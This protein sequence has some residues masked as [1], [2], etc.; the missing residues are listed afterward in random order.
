MERVAFDPSGQILAV[1]GRRGYI[2]LVDWRA[3][4]AQVIGNVKMNSGVQALWWNRHPGHNSISGHPE[5]LTLGA[6]AEV[7]VWDIGERRCVRR[8]KE[9]GGYGTTVMSGDTS[10]RYLSIGSKS[11]LVNVYGEDASIPIANSPSPSSS[12][13]KPQKTLQNLTTSISTLRFNHDSQLLAMASSVK[14]D[15]MRLVH[16]PSLTAFSNWP[17]SSTPLGHVTAIDFSPTSQYIA[18]GNNRGRALL[19]Q[20]P[21]FVKY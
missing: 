21:Q 13:P 4:G 19:Y 5:L 11:G 7:Y 20:I 12:T 15:Q 14:K 6:D 18:I 1:A 8:W 3:G 9:E 17:T 2:H 10:G 16:L